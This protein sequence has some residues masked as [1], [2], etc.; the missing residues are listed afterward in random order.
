MKKILIAF[1]F[2]FSAATFAS[3]LQ[4]A[5]TSA[6]SRKEYYAKVT[7]D[8]IFLY[9]SPSANSNT[10][11]FEV[12][13][14]YFVTILAEKDDF[15][16]ARYNDVFGYIK[17][18]QVSVMDG[19]PEIPYYITN[20]RMYMRGT[21]PLLSFPNEE[22]GEIIAEVP[23]LTDTL[24][25]YGTCEGSDFVPGK[26]KTWYFCKYIKDDNIYQGYLYSAYCD[27]FKK[28]EIPLNTET[29][30]LLTDPLFPEIEQQ[31]TASLSTTA[32]VLIVVGVS[33]PCAV[34]LYLLIRP[35]II[36][37]Q[38][39]KVKRTPFKRKR[40]TDYFEFDESDLG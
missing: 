20:F 39:E 37:K 31:P 40:K 14:S 22:N 12:P 32:K 5:F 27:G 28:E 26:T 15:Y 35:T 34:I 3:F 38:P 4:P 2:I 30:P 1:M 36:H 17:K 11:L 23:Y 9:S 24:V 21:L 33:V 19:K 13:K 16:Y 10:T 6:E 8:E 18:N 7:E 25:Y 29:F